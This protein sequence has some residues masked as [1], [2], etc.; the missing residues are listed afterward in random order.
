MLCYSDWVCM[1]N[2]W[3]KLTGL[4]KRKQRPALVMQLTGKGLEAIFQQADDVTSGENSVKAI[5]DNRHI[6][7]TYTDAL[8]TEILTC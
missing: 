7:M 5:L 1:V 4:V 6:Q 3:A 8:H 2:I